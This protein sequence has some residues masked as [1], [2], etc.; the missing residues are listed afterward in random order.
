M[1][2]QDFVRRLT[3]GPKLPLDEAAPPFQPRDPDLRR[4]LLRFEKKRRARFLKTFLIVLG[5]TVVLV[6]LHVIFELPILL[7]GLGIVPIAVI[8]SALYRRQT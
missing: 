5:G 3:G 1:K 4:I 7:T 2:I 6:S 8:G